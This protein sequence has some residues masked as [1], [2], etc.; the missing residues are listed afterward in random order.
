MYTGK[1]GKCRLRLKAANGAVIAT[2]EAYSSRAQWVYLFL[3]AFQ[4]RYNAVK[5]RNVA[6]SML[7][8]DGKYTQWLKK[9]VNFSA[10]PIVPHTSIICIQSLTSSF[11]HEC[12]AFIFVTDCLVHFYQISKL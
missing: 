5:I 3:R 10:M 12:I 1:A 4:V 9:V 2:S 8:N 11:Q 6:S 7:G